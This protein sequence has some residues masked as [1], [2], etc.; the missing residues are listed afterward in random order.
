MHESKT[1]RWKNNYCSVFQ[2]IHNFWQQIHA[3]LKKCP[4]CEKK[5]FCPLLLCSV[6]FLL[7]RPYLR[8][9]QEEGTE[10]DKCRFRCRRHP[11]QW[12]GGQVR[13]GTVWSKHPG[14]KM[15]GQPITGGQV[16]LRTLLPMHATHKMNWLKPM[17]NSYCGQITVQYVRL[18]HNHPV[19]HI[20]LHENYVDGKVHEWDFMVCTIRK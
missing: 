6:L 9:F 7:T 16:R 5:I 2:A 8:K 14:D 3:F 12:A 19:V 13:L 17:G 18:A 20:L 1:L 4:Q 11:T 10:Q 15:N